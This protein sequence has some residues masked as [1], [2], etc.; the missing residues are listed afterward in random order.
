MYAIL[1][2]KRTARRPPRDEEGPRPEQTPI[3]RGKEKKKEP[4]LSTLDEPEKQYERQNYQY[5][6]AL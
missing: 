3:D 5:P 2:I 6:D 4:T 1:T